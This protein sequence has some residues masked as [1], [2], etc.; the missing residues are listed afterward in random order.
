MRR[1]RRMGHRQADILDSLVR[2]GPMTTADLA[3]DI[4]CEYH[5]ARD[6]LARLLE[7]GCVAREGWSSRGRGGTTPWV[8]WITSAGRR[9]LKL[10]Q[11]AGIAPGVKGTYPSGGA[12]LRRRRDRASR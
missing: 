6:A 9:E 7:A 11:R 2:S 4:G 1:L 12:Y 5:R 8:Y 3:E 10:R